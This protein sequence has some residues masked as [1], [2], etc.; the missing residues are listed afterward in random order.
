MLVLSLL[1]ERDRHGYEIAKQIERRSDG[2][3]VFH[4]A[5]L[6]TLLSRLEERGWIR[7][8][9]VEKA[10]E[11]RRRFYRLTKRGRDALG[12]ERAE[13]LEFIRAVH[14]IVGFDLEEALIGGRDV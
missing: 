11:R 8:R 3:L 6:Y 7:G 9:W 10:G 2:A 13:W 12:V 14:Q 1:G 4:V 5:S